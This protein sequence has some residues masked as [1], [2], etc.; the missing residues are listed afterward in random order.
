MIGLT[1]IINSNQSNPVNLNCFLE[2][3]PAGSAPLI[4]GGRGDSSTQRVIRTFK[5]PRITRHY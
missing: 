4:K 5:V 1:L 3:P 2:D